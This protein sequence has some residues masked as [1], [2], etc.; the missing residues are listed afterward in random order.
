[1]AKGALLMAES[2][3]PPVI[4]EIM[5]SIKEFTAKKNEVIHGL[6]QIQTAG[7][8]TSAKL[9]ALGTKIG[10]F[11]LMGSVGVAAYATKLAFS[12]Q[13]A[14][15]QVARTTNLTKKQIEELSP[16]ILKV[17]KDTATAATEIAAAYAQAVKGGLSLEQANSAVAASAMFAKAENGNL[18]QTLNAALVVQRLHIQGT[19]SVAQT[20]DIF[21]NAVKNSKLTANDLNAAMEGRA[22]SVFAAY[23]LSIQTI[24]T[25]FAGLANQNIYGTQAMRV[26]NAALSG[27]EKSMT[28]ASGKATPLNNALKSIGLNQANLA[29]QV[30][31]PGGFIMILQQ[32]NDGFNK[33]A[34][35]GQKALGI[36]AFLNS[37]FGKTVGPT[38][39]NFM[40]QL[41]MMLK[42]YGD[43]NKSGS[44]LAQFQEWLKSPSGAW[45][46]FLTSLQ[47]ALIPLGDKI[48]P[49]LT[50]ALQDITK[51]LDAPKGSTTNTALNVA[52]GA[53]G[54]LMAGFTASKLAGYGITIAEAFGATIAAGTAVVIGSAVAA[55]VLA[56]LAL[57]HFGAPTQATADASR[58]AWNE[59]KFKGAVD[60]AVMSLNTLTGWFSKVSHIPIPNIPI[61]HAAATADS[62]AVPGGRSSI[63]PGT[64]PGTV[65]I[66]V[67][68]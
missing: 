12:Y 30:N 63:M 24:T 13:E 9:S 37:A 16:T 62:T 19:K 44:T 33:Y 17:S 28:S 48:L 5:A 36:T 56:A 34:T 40:P 57:W 55:G 2:L 60:V 49:K 58:A 42:M 11:A 26:M 23:G 22:L 61:I 66:K 1:M 43:A 6:E 3:M 25:L 50:T 68:P 35:A 20:V 8:T 41:P 46:N 14:L 53:G 15:D 67:H 38:L 52:L 18:T 31:K 65:K 29:S 64:S 27:I 21:T 59:N 32:I 45:Q 47:D 4:I 7:N 54:A 51:I 39:A 10:N